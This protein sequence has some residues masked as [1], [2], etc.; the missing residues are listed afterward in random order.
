MF[1]TTVFVQGMPLLLHAA[2]A[3]IAAELRTLQAALTRR[4]LQAHLPA[5]AQGDEVRML[6]RA[7][8]RRSRS[9]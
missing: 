3:T 5:N 8:W 2:L 1:S 9:K 6:I 4:G 7:M